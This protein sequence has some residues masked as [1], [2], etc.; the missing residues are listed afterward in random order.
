MNVY[1]SKQGAPSQPM[2]KEEYLGKDHLSYTVVWSLESAVAAEEF[3]IK[4]RKVC[5][6]TFLTVVWVYKQK[7]GQHNQRFATCQCNG[8]EKN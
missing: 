7:I 1:F 4:F 3:K 6:A 5:N 8:N 2:L